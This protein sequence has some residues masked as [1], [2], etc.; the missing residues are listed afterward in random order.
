VEAVGIGARG[1]SSDRCPAHPH[2]RRGLPRLLHSEQQLCQL[3]VRSARWWDLTRPLP[4][5][6]RPGGRPGSGARLRV[7]HLFRMDRE[8]NMADDPFRSSS[9]PAISLDD[10]LR[11]IT[12]VWT[13]H[14]CNCCRHEDWE[15]EVSA[16][17][18]VLPVS[19]GT[20]LSSSSRSV[21]LAYRIVC[22]NCGN[23][24]LISEKVILRWL[25]GGSNP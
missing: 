25:N 7:D 8:Q 12:E 2:L 18:V 16:P 19:S 21:F 22:E 23:V 1:C 20:A 17:V 3:K 10:V 24:R 13:S 9:L 4:R 14:R 6:P 15:I 5:A 11:F